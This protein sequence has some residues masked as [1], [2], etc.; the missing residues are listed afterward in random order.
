MADFS[1]QEHRVD[2]VE[3][4]TFSTL[5]KRENTALSKV[6]KHM[7]FE[8]SIYDMKFQLFL[9]GSDTARRE[10]LSEEPSPVVISLSRTH[11]MFET[12]V[13]CSML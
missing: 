13:M 10:R 2:E 8:F 3:P 1:K 12:M 5:S 4:A 7:V 9:R 6:I 11:N